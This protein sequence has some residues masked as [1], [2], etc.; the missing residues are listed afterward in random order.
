MELFNRER[1]ELRRLLAKTP[2]RG[3]RRKSLENVIVQNFKF[4]KLW[5]SEKRATEDA[6]DALIISVEIE[7]ESEGISQVDRLQWTPRIFT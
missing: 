1:H 7:R 2:E 3:R 5:E 4:E 6:E